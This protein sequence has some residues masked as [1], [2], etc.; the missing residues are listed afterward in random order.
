MTS[1]TPA[2]MAATRARIAANVARDRFAAPTTLRVLRFIAAH[3]D[4]AAAECESYDGTTNAPFSRMMRSLDDAVELITMH[5]DT[6]FTASVVDYITA[7]LSAVPLPEPRRLYPVDARYAE[8]ESALRAELAQLHADTGAAE[9]DPERWFSAVLATLAKWARLA[10]IVAVDNARPY[11]R[12][13]VAALHL[14]CIDCGGST[15]QFGARQWA[16]CACGKG[17]AW[18]DAMSCECFGYAC[19]AVRHDAAN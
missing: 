4:S 5:T 8:R 3:L 18:A 1:T 13:R 16:V 12:A 6:R 10:G 2:R 15:I 11:N 19:P 9:S 7:P 14:K 17:Q